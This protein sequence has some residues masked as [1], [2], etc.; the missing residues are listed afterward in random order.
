MQ[1]TCF[2]VPSFEDFFVISLVQK[3]PL[4]TGL[5]AIPAAP[6]AKAFDDVTHQ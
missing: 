6:S 4:G 1:F 5:G 2:C 3:S